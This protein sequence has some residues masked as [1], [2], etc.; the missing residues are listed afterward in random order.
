MRAAADELLAAFA[1]SDLDVIARRCAD[2]V[3][4]WGTD[5]GE[6]WVGKQRV[7][8]SFA[9]TFDLEVRWLGEPS[10]GD[11]WVAGPAQFTLADGSTLLARVTMVF[12]EG[13]LEH[14]HYSIAVPG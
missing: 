3:I 6:S 10:E 2:D 11:N 5:V 12:A 1:R 4:L 7:L 13:L 9:G 14:A 8:E